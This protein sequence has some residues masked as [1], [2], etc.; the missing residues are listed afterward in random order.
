MSQ[1]DFARQTQEEKTL[2]SKTLWHQARHMSFINRFMGEDQNSIIQRVTELK[3][4]EKG[5]RAVIT[6]LADLQ[7]DGVAGDRQL[8]G[9]EEGMQSYEQVIR[10]DQL[11]H[12]NRNKGR[13]S[14]QKTVVNFRKASKDAL[15]FWMSDRFDQLGILAVAGWSY[16][17]TTDGRLR[18]DVMINNTAF[19]DL[20]FAADV[21][22]PSAKRRARW[23]KTS[24]LLEWGGATSDVTA[25]DKITWAMLVQL[26]AEMRQKHI[27][28]IKEA[29][30]EESYHVWLNPTAMAQ[31]KLDP[32]YM[33]N[34]RNAGPRD[35]NNPLF[36]G[37]TIKVDGLYIS[38]HFHI[39]STRGA[40]AGNKWGA[41]G[42]VE[43]A[44]VLCLGAQALAFAD[45]NDPTW[46]EEDYDY[47]NSYGIATGKIAGFLKPQFET[48]YE[49][50]AKEDFGVVSVFVAI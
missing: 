14:D 29:G 50:G 47:K 41:G 18:T 24:G 5:T 38:E 46:E 26:K 3:K 37:N 45:Y 32:D 28:G 40:T 16:T 11:R 13:M 36:T 33:A 2:W 48:I 17:K 44:V 30:G 10:V 27:R 34:L 1:T 9:R 42:A 35:A 20:E 39:P 15:S 31:L 25:T 6:L 8:E 12:A 49:P 21:K 4:D 22:A 43:G 7:G 23:N 19:S